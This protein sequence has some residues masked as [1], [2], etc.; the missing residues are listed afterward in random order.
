MTFKSISELR[1]P[2]SLAE[3]KPKMLLMHQFSS[4]GRGRTG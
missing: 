1:K 2:D 3:K 4:S